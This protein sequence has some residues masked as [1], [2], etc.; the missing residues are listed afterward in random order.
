MNEQHSWPRELSEW[1]FGVLLWSHVYQL[2]SLVCGTFQL[3][4]ECSTFLA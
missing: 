3:S 1:R 4:A 2:Q